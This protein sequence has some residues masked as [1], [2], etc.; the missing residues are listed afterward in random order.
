MHQDGGNRRF[1]FR[2]VVADELAGSDVQIRIGTLHV[3]AA[4]KRGGGAGLLF[5]G[6]HLPLKTLHVHFQAVFSR[7]LPSEFNW[8]TMCI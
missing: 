5:L 1:L 7:N 6:L 3:H 4:G 2:Q 8:E